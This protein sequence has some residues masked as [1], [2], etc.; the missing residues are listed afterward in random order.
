MEPPPDA[1][2]R[3]PGLAALVREAASDLVGIEGRLWR[4]VADLAAR[5]GA[6]TEAYLA[7]SGAVLRPTRVYLLSSLTLFSVLTLADPGRALGDA[8]L[9][10]EYRWL[11]SDAPSARRELRD[12][13]GDRQRAARLDAAAAVAEA[14]RVD[15][16]VLALRDGRGVEA[17]ARVVVPEAAAPRPLGGTMRSIDATEEDLARAQPAVAGKLAEW[18]PLA[19][20]AGVPFLAFGL[21]LAVGQGRSGVVAVLVALHAHAASFLALTVAVVA[22]WVSGWT[23]RVGLVAL[24]LALGASLVWLA[25]ALRS[26]YRIGW[27]R[28]VAAATGVGVGYLVAVAAGFAVLYTVALAVV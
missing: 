10:A 8:L 4:T 24:P 9:E 6:L 13:L 20:I 22:L 27:P 3:E 1:P 15:S 18:L 16:L 14:A 28:A 11:T 12:D 2:P 23:A 5:P 19:L 17:A 26:T 25:L 7:A 21:F